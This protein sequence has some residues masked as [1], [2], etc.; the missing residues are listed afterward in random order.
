MFKSRST[1]RY[2][3][4]RAAL[5]AAIRDSDDLLSLLD[6]PTMPVKTIVDHCVI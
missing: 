5:E 4:A 3:L 1:D 6:P 2:I